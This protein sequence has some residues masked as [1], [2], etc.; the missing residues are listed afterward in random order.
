M[1]QSLRNHVVA[2]SVEAAAVAVVAV[3]VASAAEVVEVV[4]AEGVAVATRLIT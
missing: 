1:R 3:V 4:A 2:A